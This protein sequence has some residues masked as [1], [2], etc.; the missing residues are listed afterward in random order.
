MPHL[1]NR[2]GQFMAMPMSWGLQ[3]S[4]QSKSIALAITYKILAQLADGE[5]QDWSEFEDH[6][7]TGYHYIVKA[8][9][10]TNAATI[11]QLVKAGVWDGSLDLR[12]GP[13]EA[14]CQIT[15]AG[16]E[17]N[18]K[19]RLKVQWVNHADYVPGPK[20]VD[21][22]TARDIAARYGAQVRAIAAAARPQAGAKKPAPPAQP[23]QSRE[24]GDD[25]LEWLGEEA[26][27]Q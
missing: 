11:E 19:T 26:P 22:M 21:D 27:A 24:P 8:N 4:K 15:V 3:D 17:Y 7:I 14:R 2:E 9:G 1:L 20:T 13:P 5:W 16:E 23:A 18:G 25:P 12:M 6:E 10:E